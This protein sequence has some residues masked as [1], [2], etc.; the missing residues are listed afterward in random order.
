MTDARTRTVESINKATAEFDHALAELDG[1]RP[2][3]TA[4]IGLAAH[5]M[6]HYTSVRPP[7]PNVGIW[8]DC[9]AHAANRCSISSA[10][11]AKSFCRATSRRARWMPNRTWR[12]R[13]NSFGGSAG[14]SGVPVS[15]GRGRRGCCVCRPSVRKAELLV[16]RGIRRYSCQIR[17]SGHSPV[18]YRPRA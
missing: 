11:S 17:Q 7:D 15:R 2:L 18:E 5:A 3:D 4:V 1:V 14:I 8:L 6:S 16:F 12:S 13:A 9:I 10:A